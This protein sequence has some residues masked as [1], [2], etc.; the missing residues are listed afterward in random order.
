[1]L[2]RLLFELP[3][4]R[5]RRVPDSGHLPHVEKPCRVVKLI[6]DF[7]QGDNF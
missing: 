3:V 6:A 4:A 7:A 1:M 2:K 5:M